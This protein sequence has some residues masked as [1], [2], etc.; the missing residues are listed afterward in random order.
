MRLIGLFTVD[1]GVSL[2][3]GDVPNICPNEDR[4]PI[5]FCRK[6]DYVYSLY[7]SNVH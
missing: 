1:I 6:D 5:K 2:A 7:N 4:M 3:V